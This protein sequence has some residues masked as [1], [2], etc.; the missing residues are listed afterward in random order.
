MGTVP[1]SPLILLTKL[2][3]YPLPLETLRRTAAGAPSGT[4]NEGG[5]LT[6]IQ[7]DISCLGPGLIIQA[8]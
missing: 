4:H 1:P 7:G 2:S 6:Q 8:R 3:V 5:S